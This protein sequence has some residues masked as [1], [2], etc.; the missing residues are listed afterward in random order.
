MSRSILLISLI[1][2][3]LISC[4]KEW[5]PDNEPRFLGDYRD[6]EVGDYL[7]ERFS[8]SA[9]GGDVHSST[10]TILITIDYGENYPDL[11]GFGREF[12]LTGSTHSFS[13]PH[14]RFTVDMTGD[15]IKAERSW[16]SLGGSSTNRW[17]GVKV[18]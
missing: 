1:F 9:T 13:T 7:V 18:E 12:A 4:Q 5:N 16:W 3:S 14:F 17:I 2:L 11:Y 8:L 6:A 10:D 15:S